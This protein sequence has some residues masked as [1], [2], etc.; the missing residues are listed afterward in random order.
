MSDII[1][2]SFKEQ[3]NIFYFT[4]MPR[5]A[6]DLLSQGFKTSLVAS[7]LLITREKAQHFL[8]LYEKGELTETSI[9]SKF[10]EFNLPFAEISNQ[11]N[12]EEFA[13][14]T[15]CAAKVLF[16]MWLTSRAIASYL[17]VPQATVRTWQKLY[18]QNKFKI[19]VSIEIK[20]PSKN[21]NASF[22]KDNLKSRTNNK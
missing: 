13:N 17:R 12:W 1:D 15:K 9:D 22:R 4:H 21:G 3:V 16:D 7:S 10:N 11:Y 6:Y 19:D 5:V 18:K 8:E 20:L 14:E 2:K